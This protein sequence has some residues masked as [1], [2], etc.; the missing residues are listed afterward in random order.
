MT[1]SKV[2]LLTGSYT[3][4]I[5][6]V[7]DYTKQIYENIEC[8]EKNVLIELI[9]AKDWS[10]RGLFRLIKQIK[11]NYEIV[12]M[13]YPTEGY[14]YSLYPIILFAFLKSTKRIITLHEY[15]QRTLKAR[16]A[17]NIFFYF[18]DFIIFTTDYEREVVIE[19]FKFVKSKSKVINIGSNIGSP[20][21]KIIWKNREFDVAYFGH[22]RPQKGI[23]EFK[24]ICKEL[25]LI[26]SKVKLSLVGQ[27]QIRFE[28]YYKKNVED[29]S[30]ISILNQGDEIVSKILQNT[31]ILLLPFPDGISMRRGSFLAGIENDCVIVS[32]NGK[33]SDSLSTLAI[34]F[35]PN[36][37]FKI[38][39]EEINKV[40]FENEFKKDLK[41]SIDSFKNKIKWSTIAQ[42]HLEIYET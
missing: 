7:G 11:N 2:A 34:L 1:K 13:Q 31:K 36:T 24:L 18:T 12:H 8:L 33:Y 38:I 29:S 5:C 42:A 21:E 40:L 25:L 10:I 9:V 14:G 3:P 30:Y 20:V 17:T 19:K 35:N 32:F 23:E 4:D 27:L 6:G 41:M 26:N 22:I 28:D 37:S 16:L 39:A 15:S